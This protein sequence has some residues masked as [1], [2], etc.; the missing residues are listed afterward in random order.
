LALAAFAS[1]SL[2]RGTGLD[3]GLFDYVLRS[4]VDAVADEAPADVPAEVPA[5]AGTAAQPPMEPAD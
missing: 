5:A 4:L 1:I 2:V 3:L